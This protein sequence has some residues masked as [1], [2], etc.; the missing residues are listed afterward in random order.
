MNI[1]LTNDDGIYA[2]GLMALA[3][4]LASKGFLWSVVAPDRERSSVGHA[5]T[6]TRPLRLWNIDQSPYIPGQKVYACDGTPSDCVVLG[7]EEV[8]SETDMVIS[9]INNGPNVGDDLTYS[10]TVSAAMEGVILGR[11]AIAVSLN[12]SSRDSECHYETAAIVVEKVLAVLEEEPL[13]E[14]VLL[15]INVP[16]LPITMLKG[17]KVTRKG[18]R[19]YEGKVTK[20]EDPKG[21][22][23]FWISGQPEDQLVEGC[24][25][26]ALANGYVSITP[27]HMDMT[28]YPSLERYSGNGLEKINFRYFLKK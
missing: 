23:Y 6:L 1:L 19:L 22:V 28:H 16:N 8:Q 7:V 11:R 3:K 14:G 21:H 26:W 20:L 17:I 12:C 18:V 15:N 27:V 25:V 9:G 4:H 5:I 2:P 10:G 13:P 24:D